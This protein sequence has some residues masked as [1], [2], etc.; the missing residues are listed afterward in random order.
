MTIDRSSK[1]MSWHGMLPWDRYDWSG[2]ELLRELMRKARAQP[3]DDTDDVFA[4]IR[5]QAV[6]DPRQAEWNAQ[7]A[8]GQ[9]PRWKATA[10]GRGSIP[11]VPDRES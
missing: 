10:A 9:W 5:T 7:K 2:I 3:D 11:P 8:A 4:S 6:P 1:K